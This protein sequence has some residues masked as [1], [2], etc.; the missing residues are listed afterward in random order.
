[1]N[2]AGVDEDAVR[3]ATAAVE[4][5]GGAAGFLAAVADEVAA[6]GLRYATLGELPLDLR[7][8][9]EMAVDEVHEGEAVS[10][11]PEWRDAE[12]PALLQ[13]AN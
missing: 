12:A 10:P 5:A 6:R 8:P 2:R 1:V 11:E 7:L 3:E 13:N 9:L 4:A